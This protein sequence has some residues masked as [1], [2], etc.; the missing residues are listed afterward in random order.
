MGTCMGIH[1]SKGAQRANISV[2]EGFC[3]NLIRTQRNNSNKKLGHC[4]TK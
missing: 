2:M 4:R 3:T 1:A